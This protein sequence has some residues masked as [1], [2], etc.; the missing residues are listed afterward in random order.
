MVF[1]CIKLG[2]LFVLLKDLFLRF[3]ENFLFNVFILGLRYGQK[4]S[5]ELRE[6]KCGIVDVTFAISKFHTC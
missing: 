2:L 5:E 4:H 6:F 3:Q 1:Q